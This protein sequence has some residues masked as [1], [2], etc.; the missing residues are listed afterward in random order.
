MISRTPTYFL[1]AITHL[2]IH[3]QIVLYRQLT[4]VSAAEG[5]SVRQFLETEYRRES[6]EYPGIAPDYDPEAALWAAQ[7]I[8]FASQLLLYRRNKETELTLILPD[9]PG[10]I[11]AGAILSADLCVRFLPEILDKTREIDTEDALAGVLEHHLQTWHYSGIGY[12]LKKE[13]LSFDI[14]FREPGLKQAYINRVIGKKSASLAE[15]PALRQEVMASLG[16]L[17]SYFWKELQ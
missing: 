2:R 6:L 17:G 14:I 5:E 16:N 7:L 4:H 13:A 15:I 8:Y 3:E 1:D 12:P 11:T 9:Y 10:E